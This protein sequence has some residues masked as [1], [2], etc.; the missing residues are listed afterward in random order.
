MDR[1]VAQCKKCGEWFTVRPD[2]EGLCKT[3]R[4]AKLQ[5]QATRQARGSRRDAA[6]LQHAKLVYDYDRD[7]PG[8]F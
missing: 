4:Y 3:H 7:F 1:P 2:S 5:R 8:E 6:L